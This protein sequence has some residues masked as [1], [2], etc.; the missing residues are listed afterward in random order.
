MRRRFDFHTINMMHSTCEASTCAIGAWVSRVGVLAFFV[1]S[2]FT[3]TAATAT[4]AVPTP[5]PTPT[6]PSML[7]LS[8]SASRVTVA[9]FRIDRSR[10]VLASRIAVVARDGSGSIVRTARAI[11]DPLILKTPEE[12]RFAFVFEPPLGPLAEP[13]TIEAT[14]LDLGFGGSAR[15]IVIPVPTDIGRA[16]DPFIATWWSSGATPG[17][18][19][20]KHLAPDGSV[21]YV[22][23]YGKQRFAGSAG[24]FYPEF[25][26]DDVA[27][28]RATFYGHDA[29]GSG[30]FVQCQ[31]RSG[32]ALQAK[33]LPGRH[34]RIQEIGR[35]AHAF[36]R[37]ADDPTRWFGGGDGLFVDS[38]IVV[39]FGLAPGDTDVRIAM[40]SPVQTHLDTTCVRGF[41]LF[42]NAA[43]MLSVF[44]RT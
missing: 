36:A 28:L 20:D 5:T 2:V 6:Q 38:P 7:G 10:P 33:L 43:Q 30:V 34:I 35:A 15:L 11:D 4:T 25:A 40:I 17:V 41:V 13:Y 26:D 9:V 3:A 37:I 32:A 16:G 24:G 23:R 42:R 12:P 21:A 19:F 22:S 8:P 31:S 18:P 27:R 29:I 39:E 14:A 1:M 44:S